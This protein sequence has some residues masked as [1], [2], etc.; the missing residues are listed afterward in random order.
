MM[1]KCLDCGHI[2]EDGEEKRIREGEECHGFPCWREYAVCPLCEGAFEETVA[3]EG[4]G[5]AKLPDELTDGYCD[6]CAEDD[7][8]KEDRRIA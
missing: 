7:E 4:C 8:D 1:Y 2:F 6:E 5:S 3:C